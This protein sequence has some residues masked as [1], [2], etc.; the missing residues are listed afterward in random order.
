LT[1]F[2][3]VV[4]SAEMSSGP[5][6]DILLKLDVLIAMMEK[7]KLKK[8]NYIALMRGVKFLVNDK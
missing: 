3:E 5:R 2:A 8:E 7:V 4:Q 6:D 1:G